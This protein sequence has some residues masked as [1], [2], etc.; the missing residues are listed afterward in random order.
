MQQVPYQESNG[1][2]EQQEW[3]LMALMLELAIPPV[4]P[5]Q[6]EDVFFDGVSMEQHQDVSTPPMTASPSVTPRRRRSGGIPMSQIIKFDCIRTCSVCSVQST[7]MWR[8]GGQGE[9][10]CNKCGLKWKRA[11]K[12]HVR[13]T[14][15]SSIDTEEGI[16]VENSLMNTSNDSKRARLLDELET[17]STNVS[18]SMQL[19]PF[20]QFWQQ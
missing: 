14:S 10:L 8:R 15:S 18:N 16:D 7:P 12:R 1:N 4:N 9:L 20:E 13:E 19:L 17:D 5:P 2:I 11:T 3:L 6:A